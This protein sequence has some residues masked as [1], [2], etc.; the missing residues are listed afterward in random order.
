MIKLI[1]GEVGAGKTK[2]LIDV[3]NKVAQS[4]DGTVVFIEKDE[5]LTYDLKSSVRLIPANSYGIDSYDLMAG[6]VRGIM[7]RD[8]DCTHIFID[9]ITKI[10]GNDIENMT[11]FFL[12][13]I[14]LT[15]E[16]RLTLIS[17]VSVLLEDLPSD[18]HKFIMSEQ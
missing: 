2:G 5:T 11:S 13:A 10:C 14:S 7:A 15:D 17:T 9:S 18:L 4:S 8:Y 12:S 16:H 3:V 6:F 1:I